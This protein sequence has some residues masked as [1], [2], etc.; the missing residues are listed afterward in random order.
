[1]SDDAL[2]PI[3]EWSRDKLELLG[4][5]LGAYATIMQA[6][7]A[8]WLRSFAYVD[9]FA[10]VGAFQDPES[11]ELVDGSPLVALRSE[12]PFDEYW[13]IELSQSRE[14]R[15]RERVAAEAPGHRTR[16]F[17]ADANSVLRG[18][19]ASTFRR[20]LWT[21]ALVF[22]DP[23]GFQV[24]WQSVVALAETR[25]IDVFVNFPIMAVNRH[26]DRDRPP[27]ARTRALLEGI[28]GPIDWIEDLYR[29]DLDMFGEI[30]WRRPPLDARRVAEAY[31]RNLRGI[32][33][34]VSTPVVMRSQTNAPLYALV[35]ASH[36]QRAVK[37]T[38]DIFTRY[39]RLR[40][41]R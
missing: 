8:T 26:L 20:E 2:Q 35:L 23:Y 32:F 21:R 3:R 6:Q 10:N 16:H 7:K 18:D 11:S 17:Q 40:S 5:Y 37:I 36:N 41:V 27:D 1:M 22:L 31:I 24:E 15:L 9:A 29:A 34:N 14:Q 13:F 19:V 28:M 4:K 38:N 39:E 30:H 12:P 33:P 25:A